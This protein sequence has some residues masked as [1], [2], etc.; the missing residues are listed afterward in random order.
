M[1]R[2]IFFIRGFISF[3]ERFLTIYLTTLFKALFSLDSLGNLLI[4]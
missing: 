2:R 3:K 4:I 1:L